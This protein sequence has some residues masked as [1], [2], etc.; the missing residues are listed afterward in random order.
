MQ[1][2]IYKCPCNRWWRDDIQALEKESECCE[3]Y[4]CLSSPSL[5]LGSRHRGLYMGIDHYGWHWGLASTA[6]LKIMVAYKVGPAS[7]TL[8]WDVF[9][10]SAAR[11][12]HWQSLA[13]FV[14]V[15]VMELHIMHISDA[16][17]DMILTTWTC[18]NLYDTLTS[19]YYPGIATA[20]SVQVV[21]P[22]SRRPLTETF[23]GL[24]SNSK[25]YPHLRKNLKKDIE[26]KKY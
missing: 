8:T 4:Y 26:K 14:Q 1:L 25:R 3:L 2:G 15:A 10:Y 6:S 11:E 12:T 21:E 18:L 23:N 17:F 13:W 5:E 24:C 22:P 7:R 9:L 20:T 19:C 16:I